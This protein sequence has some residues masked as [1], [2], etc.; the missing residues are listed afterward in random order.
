MHNN[1]ITINGQKMGKSLGNFITLEEIFTGNHK[2]LEQAYSPMTVRFFIL[3]AHYRSTLDFSNQALQAAQKGLERLLKA[4]NTINKLKPSNTSDV[5]IEQLENDIYN[6]INDDLN[7]PIVISKLFDGVKI[8]N[9]INSGKAKI[10]NTNLEKLKKLYNTF[11]F[12]I[13]GIKNEEKCQTN[14]NTL[15]EVVNMLLEMRMQAKKDKNYQL[16]D[17]IRDKLTKLGFVIKDKK[18]G[19]EWEYNA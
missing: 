11:V 10:N 5:N 14:N 9:S 4:T 3:Q 19:F 12:D 18:D 13:L 6:A 8:I 17:E 1:M 2:L 15:N 16:A 7:T